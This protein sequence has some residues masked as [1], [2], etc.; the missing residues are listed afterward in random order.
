MGETEKL[1]NTDDELNKSTENAENA[2]AVEN[3]EA[4]TEQ[5]VE[6]LLILQLLLF[7]RHPKRRP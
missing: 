3:G 7:F 6:Q 1:A 2:P 4:K 5:Q